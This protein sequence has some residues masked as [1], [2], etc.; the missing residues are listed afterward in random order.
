MSP[1]HPVTV[2]KLVQVWV[3]G[4]VFLRF[5]IPLDPANSPAG[6]MRGI[7]TCCGMSERGTEQ[8]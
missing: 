7:P 5:A 2:C 8:H 1:W 3:V 4:L 6:A